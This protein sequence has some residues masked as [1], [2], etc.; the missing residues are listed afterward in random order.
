MEWRK[1]P[2]ELPAVKT[3]CLVYVES[4]N[5]YVVATY[6]GMWRSGRIAD[7]T[8][9]RWIESGPVLIQGVTHWLPVPAR[10]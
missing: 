4:R 6:D 9:H 1:F 8:N 7:P 3:L 10:N 5:V 2:D